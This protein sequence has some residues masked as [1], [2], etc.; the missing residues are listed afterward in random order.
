MTQISQQKLISEIEYNRKLIMD[1]LLMNVNETLCT[2]IN[3]IRILFLYIVKL[4]EPS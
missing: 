4:A 2:F 3:S 1:A